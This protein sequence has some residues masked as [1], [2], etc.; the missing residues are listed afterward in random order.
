MERGRLIVLEGID[1]SGKNTQLSLISR[2]LFDLNKYSDLKITREPWKSQYG[3]EIRR[4]LK[5]DKDPTQK[6]EE[7]FDLYVKDRTLH[8]DRINRWLE[9]GDIVISDRYYYSTIAYQQAQ[10][11]PLERILEAN[12]AFPVP[13]LVL[14]FKIAPEVAVKRIAKGRSEKE[15]FEQLE[16]LTKVSQHFDNMPGYLGRMD[17]LRI[18]S[19]LDYP[20][21]SLLVINAN[22]KPERV[23]TEIR[24]CIKYQEIMQEIERIRARTIT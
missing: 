2:E 1:G 10:G 22:Q 14:L 18:N 17:K 6:A 8:V 7:C 20:A 13:D 9:E 5:S 21:E 16:F 15:K 4:I 3:Q 11:I 24:R 23:Y 12:R 19:G